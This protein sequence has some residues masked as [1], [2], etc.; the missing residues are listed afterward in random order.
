MDSGGLDAAEDLEFRI[1]NELKNER[2]K[3]NC[4][5]MH[6]ACCLSVAVHTVASNVPRK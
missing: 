4:F 6:L 5:I 2:I 3:M 1:N